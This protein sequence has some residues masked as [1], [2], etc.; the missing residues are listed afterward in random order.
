MATL[1]NTT[2]P[3]RAEVTRRKRQRWLVVK[4]VS[5][6]VL[7]YLALLPLAGF[8]I[9]PFLWMLGSSFKPIGSG[10][11]FPPQ[12]IPTTWV[13]TNYP[14][15]FKTIPFLMYMRNSLIVTGG[16]IVGELISTSIVAYSFARL[17]YPGR[18]VAFMLLLATMMI[19]FP[20]TMVPQFVLFNILHWVD[21]YLPLIIPAWFAPAFAVFLL[22]QFFMTV[23][24]ELDDA[25]K[26]DGCN[27]FRIL[28]Q[29]LMPLSKPALT[30]VAIFS[31]TA[32]WNDF[33]GPLIYLS[34]ARKFTLALGINYLR[35][36]RGGGDLA[37]QM[38][39]SLMFSAPCIILFFLA[40]K[41]FVQGIVTTGIKG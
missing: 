39:A 18:D 26:V 33:L 20:V 15:V 27:E 19:P 8:I 12:F 10:I 30:T 21:T 29:I 24:R 35:S 41:Y 13:W 6:R 25:A 3:V 14:L 37:P 36:F 5:V 32:N 28:F 9:M 16:V 40:Q 7:V 17:R 1:A 23:N 4:R 31:F 11:R 22:R 38:A 2:Q 34:D